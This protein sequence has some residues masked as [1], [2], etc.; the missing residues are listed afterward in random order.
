MFVK[1][2]LLQILLLTAGTTA[3]SCQLFT[4]SRAAAKQLA[5]EQLA[6]ERL[7]KQLRPVKFLLEQL[8]QLQFGVTFQVYIICLPQLLNQRLTLGSK[9]SIIIIE[10]KRKGLDNMFDRDSL[11]GY[12]R[13]IS[14]N[15]DNHGIRIYVNGI[16]IDDMD[17]GL[18]AAVH[19]LIAGQDSA[20]ANIIATAD[21]YLPD[22]EGTDE[23]ADKIHNVLCQA[24]SLTADQEIALLNQTY[25]K[26]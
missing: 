20:R 13:V 18:E 24:P 5:P 16:Y 6:L 21:V 9:C 22:I 25:D 4:T 15:D 3:A 23:V 2:S 12:T 19:I 1:Y 8:E 7:A 26:F 10:R 17:N 11:D 14:Y